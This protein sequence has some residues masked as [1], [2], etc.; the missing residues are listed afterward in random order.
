[1]FDEL[2]EILTELFDPGPRS[3]EACLSRLKQWRNENV[4]DRDDVRYTLTYDPDGN[5]AE[6]IQ[7]KNYLDAVEEAFE[8]LQYHVSEWEE[9]PEDD[10]E[11]ESQED[12]E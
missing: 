2:K 9:K 8:S 1:V 7:S 5:L 12:E 4:L 11:A 10:P 6:Q 3:L